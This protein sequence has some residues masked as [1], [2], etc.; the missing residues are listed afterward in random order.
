MQAD[1]DNLEAHA[2]RAEIYRAR[3]T[4]ESSLMAKGV[5]GHLARQ[6]TL[7]VAP[8]SLEPQSRAPNLLKK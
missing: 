6:S 7:K 2:V 5:F 1:P 4:Q 8:D 3:R